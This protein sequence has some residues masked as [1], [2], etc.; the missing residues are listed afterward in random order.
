MKEFLPIQDHKH[1]I[2][3]TRSGAILNIDVKTAEAEKRRA[4]VMNNMIVQREEIN[5]IKEK[6]TEIDSIKSDLATIKDLLQ[7]IV[8][9]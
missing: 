9:K 3:D 7:R 8:N 2:R 1:L 5:T 6:L 4:L